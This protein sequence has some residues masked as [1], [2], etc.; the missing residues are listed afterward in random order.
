M[1]PDLDFQN[2][3]LAIDVTHQGA[4]ALEPDGGMNIVVA[5]GH[6]AP[7]DG[8]GPICLYHY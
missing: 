3:L 4:Y 8:P 7:H 5:A 6:N 2:S 1:K